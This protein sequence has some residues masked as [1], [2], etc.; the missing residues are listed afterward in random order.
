MAATGMIGHDLQK[1][2]LCFGSDH[3]IAIG[4]SLTATNLPI[5]LSSHLNTLL[6][7]GRNSLC[8]LQGIKTFTLKSLDDRIY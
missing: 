3:E 6:S 5:Y 1:F 7:S 2:F 8:S 4:P